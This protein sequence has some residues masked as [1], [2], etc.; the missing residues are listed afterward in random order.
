MTYPPL[1]PSPLKSNPY[2]PSAGVEHLH[3]LGVAHRDI[4]PENLLL[5]RNDNLQITDYGLATLFRH[6]GKDTLLVTHQSLLTSQDHIAL[7]GGYL[8]WIS[9]IIAGD[10][11]L[12]TFLI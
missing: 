1:S 10:Q 3:N 7:S 11:H 6:R 2:S 4:K 9:A 8:T 12:R 5:D